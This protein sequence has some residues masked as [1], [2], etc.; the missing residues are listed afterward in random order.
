MADRRSGIV[1]GGTWCVDRNKVV[2]CWPQEDTAV[3]ILAV[4]QG[5]GGSACNL[6][7]DVRKLDPDLPVETI[8]L[9]GDDADGRF[10]M[11]E[12]DA[13]GI[14]RRQM[15]VTA[16]ALTQY[17]DAFAARR[18]GQRTHLYY[19]GTAALLTP[20][21]FDFARTSGRLLHLGLPGVHR[22][23]DR[24]W[25]GDASGWVTVLRQARAA[26][27]ET[28]LELVSVEPA[29]IAALA[30]PCLPHLDLLIVNDVEIGAIAG[31]PTSL[32]GRTDPEACI[33][34][35]RR[36]LEQ[37]AMRLVVVHFPMGAIALARGGEPVRHPSVRVPQEAVASANGA[38][39]AFAAG[40]VY[41]YL[42]G[43][44]LEDALALAHATAA[45]SLR[46]FS[47]TG[48]VESWRACLELA[49][50]WG[51]RESIA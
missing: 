13:Y 7:I 43:W 12:A 17:T 25:E 5:G 30:Q 36:V 47:T 6:A 33:R 42:A 8:G 14:D 45:A 49:E 16:D 22:R 20:A 40:M 11:A 37:G 4:E 19:Q 34:A 9:V 39:D 21:H 18:S 46:S 44:A 48:A 35:V 10:L 38:G 2:E 50:R 23:M 24:P 28:N 27:L 3:E 51:W 41:G 26:G 29:R 15:Q 1:T 31:E 32:E